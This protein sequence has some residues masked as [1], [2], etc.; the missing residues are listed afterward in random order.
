[1]FGV[2]T[3]GAGSAPTAE[4]PGVQERFETS[5]RGRKAI[6]VFLA[7]VIAMML[8]ANM[9][10]GPAGN[11]ANAPIEP[12]LEATGLSQGWYL[13][14]PNPARKT[15]RLVAVIRFTDG[16]KAT[17]TPPSSNRFLGAYRDY[18][19]RGVDGAGQARLSGVFWPE[20]ARYLI[21]HHE[22][23]DG[24]RVDQVIF[25]RGVADTPRPGSRDAPRWR[26]EKLSTFEPTGKGS[27][28]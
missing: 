15:V 26:V 17:W 19:W 11:A 18:H 5:G 21:A 25:Y 4:Q 22:K 9:P 8:I 12:V 24:P 2:S 13:F 6:T 27:K 23:P 1:M 3:M 10:P 20:L 28:S 16:S 7:V 14:A